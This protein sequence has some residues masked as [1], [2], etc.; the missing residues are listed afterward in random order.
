MAYVM[1][2]PV[3]CRRVLA[4][5]LFLA[6]GGEA[7]AQTSDPK[8]LTQ[9]QDRD[10]EARCSITGR[11]FHRLTELRAGTDAR[12]AA[13]SVGKWAG[14]LGATG[15]HLRY[16]YAKAAESAANFVYSHQDLNPVT[17]AHLGYRS[18]EM[19]YLFQA[20]EQKAA[21]GQI[22]LLDAAKECQVSHP[23][24]Y[25]NPELRDCIQEGARKIADR[26]KT[27]KVTVQK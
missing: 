4:A 1:R 3:A 17:L 10:W 20:D 2:R 6:F 25:R 14:E 22:L 9:L 11:M 18:C 8:E 19:Q 16:D 7:A 12:S 21:A 15:S 5:F 27:A 13:Y 26:V 24:A 23:G